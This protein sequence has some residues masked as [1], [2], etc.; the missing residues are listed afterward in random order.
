[1]AKADNFATNTIFLV[2]KGVK[3]EGGGKYV[4]SRVKK[5]VEASETDEHLNVCQSERGSVGRGAGVL[6]RPHQVEEGDGDHV[7][8]SEMVGSSN[9][10]SGSERMDDDGNGYWF[11]VVGW[12]VGT[13]IATEL[14]LEAEIDG[15]SGVEVGV[16]GPQSGEALAHRAEGVLHCARANWLVAGGCTTVAV[17]L[18]E[19]LEHEDGVGNVGKSFVGA[20]GLTECTPVE[21]SFVVG[22]GVKE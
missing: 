13:C 3:G 15:A 7:G 4:G 6:A 19:D 22:T 9:D 5:Q 1:M 11:D 18:G 12:R 8:D 2:G 21:P 14:V 17:V 20:E 10:G 16:M